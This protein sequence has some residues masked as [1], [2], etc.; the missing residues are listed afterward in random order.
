GDQIKIGRATFTVRGVIVSEPG[1]TFGAFSVGP[2]VLIDAADLP[3]TGLIAFGSRA[4]HQLLLR[5]PDEDVDAV[6]RELRNAF[7]NDFVGIRSS[8]RMDDQMGQNLE[9]AENY[10]SL[11]GF[12][13]LILGGIG[14]SSVTRV[15][16]QQKIRSIAVLKCVGSTT[17]QVLSIYI[18]QVLV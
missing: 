3:S 4:T 8:R 16:V 6:A 18:A 17:R 7:I 13:V 1:R 11:V 14:V 15:F 10:L 5:V 12:V 9:R 2:R